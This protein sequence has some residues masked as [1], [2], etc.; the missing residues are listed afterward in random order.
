MI[1]PLKQGQTTISILT[2]LTEKATCG[3][4]KGELCQ[5][6]HKCLHSDFYLTINIMRRLFLCILQVQLSLTCLIFLSFFTTIQYPN[7]PSSHFTIL[8]SVNPSIFFFLNSV[9]FYCIFSYFIPFNK[10][11]YF[12]NLLLNISFNGVISIFHNICH[13]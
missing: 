2:K 1:R 11:N 3:V 5:Q 6:C 4:W 8:H 13:S 12:P 7:I 10:L 9:N